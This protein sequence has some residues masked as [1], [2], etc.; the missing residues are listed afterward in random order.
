MNKIIIQEKEYN[1]ISSLD[2]LRLKEYCNISKIQSSDIGNVHKLINIISILSNIPLEIL[3]ECNISQLE[4]IDISF[5]YKYDNK[6]DDV[7]EI[8]GVKYGVV[9]DMKSL[10]LGEYAD[11]DQFQSTSSTDELYNLHIISAIL[12]RPVSEDGKLEKY[13]FETLNQ[14]A[15]LFKTELAVKN[16]IQLT[17][18]F[19][20]IKSGL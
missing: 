5:L 1:L 7:I 17:N 13:N 10:S 11:L 16:I 19:L 20:N 3:Y 14:R 6:I 2:E 9:K 4:N 8:K 15:E 18:F 12:Y